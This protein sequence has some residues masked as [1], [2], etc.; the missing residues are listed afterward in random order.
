MSK[1]SVKRPYTVVV[2][3][4][5]AIILGVMSFMNLSTDLLPSMNLPY[6]I[7]ITTYAGASPEEVEQVVSSP[8]ESSMATVTNIKHIS[9]SSSE[10]YST[11]IL[12]FN[13]D[14]NMDS[15][16]IE[17]REKLDM[18]KS[19]WPDTVG[20]PTIMKLNP[21]MMPVMVLSVD[22]EGKDTKAITELF[23]DK[24]SADLESIDGVASVSASGLTEESLKVSLR[25]DLV[26]DINEQLMAK[27]ND[28]FAKAHSEMDDAKANLEEGKAQLDDNGLAAATQLL[29]AS[30]AMTSGKIQMMSTASEL[31]NALSTIELGISA[32]SIT[33]QTISGLQTELDNRQQQYTQAVSQLQQLES[34]KA[35]LEQLEQGILEL[36]DNPLMTD[37][38][39]LMALEMMLSGSGIDISSIP[40]DSVDNALTAVAAI[41]SGVES[42][43]DAIGN[44]DEQS[45]EI[46]DLQNQI[47][48]LSNSIA[49][50]ADELQSMKNQIQDGLSQISA[51]SDM[52][53]TQESALNEANAQANAQMS[54][55]RIQ[56]AIGESQLSQ[57][58][59]QLDSSEEQAKKNADLSNIITLDMIKGMLTA[60]NFKM[61]AGYIK[62]NGAQ[63][64]VRVGDKIS[65]Q[66]SLEDLVLFDLSDYDLGQ[67]TL[68]DVADV[69]LENNAD[70]N[71]ARVNG[72]EAVLVTVEKQTGY[73][74]A[75]VAKKIRDYIDSEENDVEGLRMTPLMDQGIYIDMVVDAVLNNL[76]VGGILAIF[77]LFVF[78]KDIKPTAVV[79]ISIPVSVIFAIALMYFSGVTLNIISLSGLALG[80]GMLVDNSIVVI[81]NIYRLRNEGMPVKEAAVTGAKQV[82]GAIIASTLTTVCIW[83]PI[84]FTEGMTKQL[85]VDLVLTIAYSLLASLIVALTVVPMASSVV[86][87]NTSEK[88]HPLFDRIVQKYAVILRWSLAHRAIVLGTVVALLAGSGAL[89]MSKGMEFMGEMDSEQIEVS[90]TMPEGSKLSDTAAMSDEVMTRILEMDDVDYV[91]AMTGSS[92]SMMGMGSGSTD[93]ENVTMYILLKEKRQQTSQEIAALIEE[94]TKDLDC[95]ISANGSTMDMSA[96]GGS[97][98]SA[99]IK[100]QDIDTLKSIATQLSKALSEVPGT[101]EVSDG[102][103]DPV[104]ELRI[105]VDKKKAMASNL[106]VAQVYQEISA[107][108]ATPTTSTTITTNDSDLPVI[109]VDGE[110]S[111]Y[112]R[113]D[114]KNL[115]FSITDM[116]GETKDVAL[117][118]IADITEDTGVSTIQR[119]AQQ[120]YLT[121]SAQVDA[122]HNATL[123]ANEFQKKIEGI[124]LPKG[125]SIEFSGENESINESVTELMKLLILGIVVMYLIMV[126]QFQSLLSPL[127]VLFTIPL[128]FTGGFIS[129]LISGNILSVIALVG[130]VM[131]C[132]II[133]NNGIVFIDYTNQLIEEGMP[134]AKAL[135]ETGITRM[136]PILMTALTTILAMSTMAMG[137]GSGTDMVQPMAIVTIGG[138][139][140]GTLLTLIVVPIIYD[141]FHF[142]TK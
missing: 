26:N 84:I 37:E 4:I 36:R 35:G 62:E 77:I 28:E 107:L 6:A 114:I 17:M 71:Y 132:G 120:R 101:I 38:Q 66:Q 99:K 11:V 67:V 43:I 32:L 50:K 142:K 52:I 135:E 127:I 41:L 10:N 53:G 49:G 139:I 86:L 23:N 137:I 111:A 31:N 3:V 88:A 42:G 8:I 103:D 106:T 115:T 93:T 80:V 110:A 60:Q 104:P 81:E 15:A 20:N 87:K 90:M 74:T 69:T 122:D 25:Q 91:G 131:L 124:D 113:D 133:V 33:Q 130:F 134:K 108:I 19:Y 79:G 118:D 83:T 109:V 63:Y 141:I 129:L 54:E 14:T 22:Q 117:K 29:D 55:A 12:E 76:I 1:F 21:D 61:P 9:S 34:Q 16:T 64:L 89:L 40:A 82:T 128:A 98:V 136:R 24:I 138:M 51:G 72:N 73:S 116:A 48:E 13:N 39:K 95:D 96:L 70:E 59:Q 121:V 102:Q 46:N 27:L 94:N 123:V 57:A 56:I 68:K 18:I 30:S 119:D 105:S 65:D 5:L 44:L 45:Q 7:V 140:Y 58:Q 85:F 97:G 75:D 125:Y 92:M 47:A 2:G 112:S 126:A 78:L 100:G